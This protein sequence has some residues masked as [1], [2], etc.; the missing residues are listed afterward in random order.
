MDII[1]LD[2]LGKYYEIFLNMIISAIAR[3]F[4]AR[5]IKML[6]VVRYS[7]IPKHRFLVMS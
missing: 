1:E 6:A 5:I 2:R 7:I 3:N 4:G